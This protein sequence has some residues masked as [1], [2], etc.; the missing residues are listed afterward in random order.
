MSGA[1][2]AAGE[3]EGEGETHKVM[4]YQ[5][6]LS[7]GMAAAFSEAMLGELV[8][9]ARRLVLAI[10]APRPAHPRMEQRGD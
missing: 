4:V 9:V 1:A 5:Y 6:D 10:Y 3:G 2:A 8:A 7:G